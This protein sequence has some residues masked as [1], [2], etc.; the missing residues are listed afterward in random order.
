MQFIFDAI[1]LICYGYIGVRSICAAQ[2]LWITFIV[3]LLILSAIAQIVQ[4]YSAYQL[5]ESK[6][7][8]QGKK[9]SDLNHIF[10]GI[11]LTCFSLAHYLFA[12]NYYKCSIWLE[13]VSKGATDEAIKLC[14]KFL[15]LLLLVLNIIIPSYIS[16]YGYVFDASSS[17][18][19]RV[20]QI[21]DG[22]VLLL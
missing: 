22:C 5:N 20:Y 9:Y 6:G 17:T 14:D 21:V 10:L 15:Y 12:C 3:S 19:K 13:K 16:W 2:K 11:Q 8:G 1:L 4:A 18:S 7:D